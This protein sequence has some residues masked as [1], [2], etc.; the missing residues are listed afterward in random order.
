MKKLLKNRMLLAQILLVLVAFASMSFLAGHFFSR[1]VNKYIANYGDE[2]INA[3]AETFKTYAKGHE[4]TL[5]DLSFA[6]ER[7]WAQDKDIEKITSELILWSHWLRANDERFA[8]FLFLYGVVDDTFIEGS[9]W[10]YPDDYNPEDRVWYIGAYKQKGEVFYSDPYIDA[11]TGEHVLTLSKLLFDENNKPFGVIALDVLLSSVAEYINHM[12]LM[13]SGY[14]MLFDSERRFIIHP[15]DELF[16]LPLE[17]LAG[18]SGIIEID[19]RLQAGEDVS[20][21]AYMS[22]FGNEN[23]GFFKKLFNGWYIGLAI[24][25]KVYYNDVKSMQIILSVTGLILA[26]LLCGVLVFMHNA[27]NRS[28]EASKFKSSFLANMSHEIRTPMNAVIGMTELLLHEPLSERQMDYVNDIDASARSLLSIINDILD[29]SKIES[30]KLTLCPVNYDF[31]NLLDNINS[32]FKFVA[33]K[34]GL[35]FRFETFG[36][37][38]RILYGDDIRLRQVLTN[39]CGNAVKFTETGY[40]RL[41]VTASD[42][43]LLFEIKDT[44]IGI[45]KEQVARLFHA[46]EQAKTDKNRTIV[47]TGLGLAISKAFVEM[48]NG[49]IMLDSEYG[50]GTIITLMLPIVLGSDTQVKQQKSGVTKQTIYAP[51]AAI[52]IVDDNEFNLKVAYGLLGLFK[53]EAKMANSGKKALAMVQTNDFDMIF[54]DHMMP[55]MDGI[56][57]TGEI[58][59][60]GE[61]FKSLPIIALTANAIQGV[62]EMFL[63]NG[64]NGFVS[65]P[66]DLHELTAVLLK[67][68]PPEKIMQK[69]EEEKELIAEEQKD[70]IGNILA[71]ITEI[72]FEIG[73]SRVSGIESMYFNN[74]EMFVNKIIDQ[75]NTMNKYQ[76]NQDVENFAITVHAV[77]SMLSTIGAMALS[78]L[79]LDLETAAKNQDATYCAQHFPGFKNSLLELHEKMAAVLLKNGQEKPPKT[80]GE[81]AFLQEKTQKALAA[82]EDYDSDA[83]TEAIGALLAYDYGTE[84]NTLLEKA[85]QAFQAYDYDSAEKALIKLNF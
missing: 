10:D 40:V 52:L 79:A 23:V 28:D 36:P 2:V 41:K 57:T 22:I 37:I 32:M 61:K 38:P 70:T 71:N 60:M 29:F 75:C 15:L 11:H 44:G 47:G 5:K 48:M 45:P 66:I 77:K 84:S 24:S 72:N 62:E 7:L 16:G 63:A 55:E 26:L 58:R 50:Q 80:G 67:W 31:N 13:N 14:G 18:R 20:A 30:G 85:F 1:I 82:A 68:L 9:A 34:K 39:L 78:E 56:E 12:Q 6:L 42:N 19:E 54:M 46:F 25:S 74:L 83:G 65:K 69:E 35:E 53:I 17:S 27:K 64:F 49:N 4:I 21:F 8:D 33:Q 73:L 43:I 76:Q 3:S 59:K 81:I 51:Q